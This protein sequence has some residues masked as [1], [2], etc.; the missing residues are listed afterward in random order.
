MMKIE[1]TAME[2]FIEIIA[3][4]ETL[5][6]PLHNRYQVYRDMVYHRFYETITNIYPI[7]SCRLGEQ[8]PILIREFQSHGATSILM[9]DMACE[10][11]EFIKQHPIG[12]TLPY[13]EDTVW[14]E[15]SEMVLLLEK[16]EENKSVFKW[17]GRY[18]LSSSARLRQLS[19]P[20]YRGDF[21]S[22]GEYP[23]L[24]FY[25]FDEEKVYFKEISSLGYD[26][27]IF[28]ENHNIQETLKQIS[29][30]YGVNE[31]N[32]KEP[33]EELLNQWCEKKILIKE[34]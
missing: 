22:I 28:L 13:L 23:L 17:E 8:L 21:E 33:L 19:Y 29:K 18:K 27:L 12:K 3:G 1:T 14:L 2:R 15:W 20:I 26:L 10:F 9:S 34:V 32:L 30:H 7:L 4:D 31:K 5:I 16:F 25:D 24:L 11:G 6:N